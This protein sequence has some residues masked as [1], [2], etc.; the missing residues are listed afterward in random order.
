LESLGP[1]APTLCDGWVTADLAAHLWVREHRPWAVPGMVT[2]S[3]RLHE[4][5]D[6]LQA[7][8]RE[9]PYSEL[10]SSLRGGAPLRT[11]VLGEAI[12]LHEF[13]V[14]HEDVRRAADMDPRPLDQPLE[15]ALWRI[16]PV[17]ARFLTRRVQG[18]GITLVSSENRRRQVRKG[19]RSVHVHGRASELFLWLYGRPAD[20]FVIANHETLRRLEAVQLGM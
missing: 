8:V 12:D 14:H 1:D 2:S 19:R 3:G 10:V 4:S 7:R 16:I 5:T 18:I 6:R 9:R 15:S 17:F 20:A 13:F 11:P